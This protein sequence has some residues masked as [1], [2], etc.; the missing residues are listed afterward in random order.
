MLLVTLI[1]VA[2]GLIL[3]ASGAFRE[4]AAGR[5]PKFVRPGTHE[6]EV[7]TAA[8][9]D[10]TPEDSEQVAEAVAKHRRWQPLSI[11]RMRSAESTSSR[12]SALLS[13]LASI[14]LLCSGILLV[15]S[16]V[17]TA[18]QGSERMAVPLIIDTDMSFDV[19]DVG[20]ICIAHAMMDRGEAKLLAVVHSSGYP[21]GIG[22]A[23]VLNNWYRH[24]DVRLGAY[25]G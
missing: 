22:A 10:L 6:T 17:L 16:G 1:S 20:A 15:A 11:R 9:D 12:L 24:H 5:F 14:A 7:V 23:S 25:K 13:P 3:M 18:T 21:E 2:A 8:D 19:D 4:Y